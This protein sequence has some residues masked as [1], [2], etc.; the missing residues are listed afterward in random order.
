M[1]EPAGKKYTGAAIDVYYDAE[2]CAHAGECV[3]GLPNVFD[4]DRRP[5]IQP[6]NADAER[7]A[8]VIGLCPSG[9][10]QFVLREDAP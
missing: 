3:R 5:W 8:E 7:V 1:T 4:V 6:D 9:A 2:V 10:L